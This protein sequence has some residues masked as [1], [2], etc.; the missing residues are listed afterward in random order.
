M[1]EVT[2]FILIWGTQDNPVRPKDTGNGSWKKI[3]V[4]GDSCFGAKHSQYK[5]SYTINYEN[6]EDYEKDE[7][8]RNF[9]AGLLSI[10]YDEEKIK[11]LLKGA[12]TEL[13]ESPKTW[14]EL[15]MEKTMGD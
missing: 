14:R 11:E 9:Y 5:L 6:K 7:V 4:G 15:R 13:C 1:Y 3:L 10:G 2:K 8:D 12:K